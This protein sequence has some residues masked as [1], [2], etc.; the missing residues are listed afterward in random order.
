[1]KYPIILTVIFLLISCSNQ[2]EQDYNSIDLQD[3][4]III[5]T[6]SETLSVFDGDNTKNNIAQIDSGANSLICTS[7]G[8]FAI[9]NSLSNSLTLFDDKFNYKYETAVEKGSNPFS[10]VW[11]NNKIYLS[12]FLK[13]QL[14]KLNSI[15]NKWQFAESINIHNDEDFNDNFPMGMAINNEKIYVAV[16]KLDNEFLPSALG[17]IAIFNNGYFNY[18]TTTGYDTVNVVSTGSSLIFVSAGEYKKGTGFI[19]NGKIDFYNP[20]TEKIEKTVSIPGAPYSVTGPLN[21]KYFISNAQKG[22]FFIYDINENLISE[23]IISD[24]ETAFISD[25]IIWNNK[26]FMLSFNENLLYEVSS[27]G[28]ILNKY[29]TGD[30]PIK[31]YKKC[32]RR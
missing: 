19:G 4:L 23:N 3:S 16:A 6:L 5:N 12:S 32:K 10:G 22:S 8:E 18:I 31:I 21:N 30:G 7:N 27:N 26:V 24:K 14:Q 28:K 2:I 1:M 15:D 9:I 20:K 11:Y 25:I 29:D 17:E 13:D